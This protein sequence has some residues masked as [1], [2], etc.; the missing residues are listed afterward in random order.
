MVVVVRFLL[1]LLSEESSVLSCVSSISTIVSSDSIK[2]RGRVFQ[3]MLGL[4]STAY[5]L[6]TTPSSGTFIAS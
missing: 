2:T 1:W 4:L 5:L 6:M 3:T